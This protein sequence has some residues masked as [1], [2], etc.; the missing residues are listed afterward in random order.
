[1]RNSITSLLCL[2]AICL[3]AHPG[4]G[5]VYD[6]D[7]TIYYTDLDRVWELN[8]TNG[9]RRVA[10]DDVHTHELVLDSNGNLY[11]EHYWYDESEQLF[12]YRIWKLNPHGVLAQIGDDRTGENTEFGFV[13]DS[14]FAMYQ[15]LSA[16]GGHHITRSDSTTQTTLHRSSFE[17]PG[18]PYLA[19][20]SS[21][22][23]TDKDVLYKL[24]GNQLSQ[25]A[26]GLISSRIPFAV[27]DK[28]HSLFG[29]WTDLNKN[30]YVAVYRGRMVRRIS[31][32]GQVTTTLTT[33]F[34]WSPL[35]GVFDNNGDL[36]LLEGS[37]FGKVRIRK[38]GQDDLL[39]DASFEVENLIIS[40]FLILTV[41]GI[42]ILW[43]RKKKKA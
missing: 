17:N 6:G 34:F 10:V 12:K 31:S 23:F 4:I 30:I 8:I 26:S 13:R 29:I 40:L 28:K 19:G 14:D 22:Y 2:L 16:N 27:Q 18:W 5:L 1:M 3:H 36:W 24:S 7:Q 38:I 42:R 37:L 41:N 43:K 21:L 35:N 15:I 20:D 33:G 39:D 25:L 32:A 9:E 11:G